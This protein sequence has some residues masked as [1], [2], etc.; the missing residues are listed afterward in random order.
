MRVF[1]AYRFDEQQLD[2]IDTVKQKLADHAKKGR[3]TDKN[4]LHITIHYLGEVE[5]KQL[6]GIR[7]VMETV[8]QKPFVIHADSIGSFERRQ[9]SIYYLHVD[10]SKQL[11]SVYRQTAVELEKRGFDVPD[12]SYRPHITLARKTILER[13][14]GFDIRPLEIHAD[15]IY[16]MES[17]HVNDRLVYKPVFSVPLGKNIKKNKKTAG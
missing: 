7:S 8:R 15:K 2:K 11:R 10:A 1:L 4:N 14:V 16:L 6:P 17:K 9:G 12:R 13:D 3:F 5:T